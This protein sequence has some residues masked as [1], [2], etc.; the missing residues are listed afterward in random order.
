MI[1]ISSLLFIAYLTIYAGLI[2]SNKQH[3]HLINGKMCSMVLVMTS[4]LLAGLM[5]GFL[6]Q[7]SFALATMGSIVVGFAIATVISAPFSSS[8]KIEALCSSVMGAMMGAMA[9]EMTAGSD[10]NLFLLFM[11]SLYMISM[12]YMLTMFKNKMVEEGGRGQRRN[13]AL[14]LMVSAILP[15]VLIGMVN[16][17]G[18][19]ESPDNDGQMN[20]H[21]HEMISE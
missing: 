19:S 18:T 2:Y 17:L 12:A 14:S 11:D 7:G 10:I 13:P 9:G 16:F 15:V 6:L 5:I 21:N 20:H 4:T 1:I 3:L 8:V